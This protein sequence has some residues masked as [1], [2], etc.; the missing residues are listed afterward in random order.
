MERDDWIDDTLSLVHSP[1][2]GEYFTFRSLLARPG[3]DC[4][5]VMAPLSCSQSQLDYTI[6]Q[7]VKLIPLRRL[8]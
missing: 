8:I 4:I 1:P 2:S 7:E 5:P 6:W 3:D